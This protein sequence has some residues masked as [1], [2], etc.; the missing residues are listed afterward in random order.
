M[1]VRVAHAKE[2]VKN[3]PG[4]Q[5]EVPVTGVERRSQSGVEHPE[6]RRRR[7]ATR[8]GAPVGDA[9]RED[10]VVPLLRLRVELGD[11]LGRVL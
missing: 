11:V 4:D 2:L 1:A 5:A 10:D 6:V 8:E 9:A 7:E 3:L